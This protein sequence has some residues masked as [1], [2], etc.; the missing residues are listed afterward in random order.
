[1]IAR[2][3]NIDAARAEA[4]AI[5]AA[6]GLTPEVK[7]ELAECD[8]AIAGVLEKITGVKQELESGE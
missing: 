8:K 2:A 3:E 1:M 5:D 6:M 4:E 7:A